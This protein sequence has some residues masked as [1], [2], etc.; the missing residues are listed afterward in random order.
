M[1]QATQNNNQTTKV[2]NLFK[3][4]QSQQSEATL[5]WILEADS[6]HHIRCIKSSPV[7]MEYRA[8]WKWRFGRTNSYNVNIP[9]LTMTNVTHPKWYWNKYRLIASWK[10]FGC[11]WPQLNG[12]I[13]KPE[14]SWELTWIWYLAYKWIAPKTGPKR[15]MFHLVWSSFVEV[16]PWCIQSMANNISCSQAKT[17][18]LLW[19]SSKF[20]SS[21]NA[22]PTYDLLKFKK[23]QCFNVLFFEFTS[24]E[25]IYV[26]QV[27]LAQSHANGYH[28]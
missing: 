10:H 20:L 5:T 11:G 8:F 15:V 16:S 9:R 26:L 23:F 24:F 7:L 19:L 14:F 17:Q 25:C 12:E 3:A 13:L 22:F 4:F 28:T 27:F 6:S 21:F 2:P 1:K 18:F